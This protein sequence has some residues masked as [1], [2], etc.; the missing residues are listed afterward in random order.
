[1]PGGAA[2][3]RLGAVLALVL[4]T[5]ALVASPAVARGGPGSPGL[6]ASPSAALPTEDKATRFHVD[7]ELTRDGS[8]HV[9]ENI[10]WTFPSDQER[11]GIE[12][13]I[14]VRAGY[15]DRKDTFR[16][17]EMSDVSAR[18]TT[19]APADVSVSEFGAYDRIR[20][21]RPDETVSGT[22]SYVVSYTLANYVNGFADHAEFYFNLVDP[23]NENTY[24]NVSA[25][26]HGPEPV[27]RVDCFYGELGSTSRCQATAGET[28]QF[29]AGTVPPGQG[30][31]ILASLPRTAFDSLEPDLRQGQVTDQGSVVT[32]ATARA[33]GLLSIGTGVTLPLLAAGLMGFLVYTRGR[34]EQYAG[35]TPGLTP[36][37]GEQGHVVRGQAPTVAVQFTPPAGVQP[38]MLGTIV[39]ETANTIDVAATVVDLAVRGY[40]TL[41]ETEKGMFGRTDWRLTRTTSPPD[42]SQLHPYELRLL[43]GIFATGDSVLLSELKNHFATTLKGVQQ[44]MYDEV[45][46]RGWFRA[47]PQLQ[48][49]IWTGLGKVMVFGGI[50]GL[51]W[52]GGPLSAMMPGNGLPVPPATV[53]GVGVVLAGAI[54]WLLGRR[55]AARTADGSAV[56]AQSLGFRQYLVTAE[57]NQ[58]RWEEAQD[59]FSRYLPFAIVFGVAEKWA[60]TFEQVAAAAAAAGHTIAYP[61]WYIGTQGYGSFT[62]LATGMD[63]FATTAGGTFT[64][65]PGS[66]GSSGFSSGGGFSGGGGGGSSGGSW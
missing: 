63:S 50:F 5:A 47:S 33:L 32:P 24:E 41:E 26:V 17:Y 8:A 15:Q 34:D 7:V 16:V 14:K 65:T 18:S 58:I 64:S 31:S 60:E 10:T 56:L 43:N 29:S 57:A 52:L 23:S 13:L 61:G 4:M 44:A 1:M 28:A 19:G 45:V 20:V 53:L 54:V 21:G 9:T 42:P 36:G 46:Q 51:F 48:R 66:S 11:H 12:R 30:V 62:H 35:L 25:S 27:D 49:G 40:L 59:I 37:H 55:M 22:Q 3:N 2:A 39:D 6:V 38:G